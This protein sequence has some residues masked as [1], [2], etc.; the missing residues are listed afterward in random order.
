M[1][2]LTLLAIIAAIIAASCTISYKFNGASIDYSKVKSIT[3]A[4][5][6]NQ[7][8]LVNPSLVNTFNDALK[9]AYSRQTRLEQT[10]R[11]GD[12][13]VE[14]EITTYSLTPLSI[15]ADA[16]AAE[17]RLTIGVRVRYTNNTNSEED[18]ER[19]FSANRTFPST[20]TLE[21]VQ[22]QLCEE[23]VEEIVDQ[24]FNATVANW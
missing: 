20:S 7:A 1:N 2:R 10:R 5:F 14:G 15:G 12:L 24:I 19:T 18:F 9:D 4:D 21:D 22:D 16:Y 23:M 6:T 8:T 17:T 11:G 13:Q 3:V